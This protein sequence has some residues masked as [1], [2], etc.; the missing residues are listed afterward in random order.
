MTNTLQHLI[1]DAADLAVSFLI[2]NAVK[3]CITLELESRG[4]CTKR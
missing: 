4:R 3:F 2:R 1:D